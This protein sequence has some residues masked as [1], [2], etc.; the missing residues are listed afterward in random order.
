MKIVNLSQYRKRKEQ[1]SRGSGR[2]NMDIRSFEEKLQD[3][4]H[5]PFSEIDSKQELIAVFEEEQ[6]KT[7]E[8]E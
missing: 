3:I 5:Q 2:S 7:D 4:M 1:T 6:R 8:G